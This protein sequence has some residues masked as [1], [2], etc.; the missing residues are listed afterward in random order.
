MFVPWGAPWRIVADQEFTAKDFDALLVFLEV[1]AGYVTAY[2]SLATS[3][4]TT[5]P[6]TRR[7]GTVNTYKF[8]SGPY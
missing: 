2:Y 6:R 8:S 3:P 4:R 1:H 7:N 5:R